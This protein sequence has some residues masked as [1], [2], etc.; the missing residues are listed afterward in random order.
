MILILDES[1]IE[2]TLSAAFF[3]PTDKVKNKDDCDGQKID[4]IPFVKCTLVY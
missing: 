4:S 2:A 3:L 1:G